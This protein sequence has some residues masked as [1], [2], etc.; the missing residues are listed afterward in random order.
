MKKLIFAV[1]AILVVT[2]TA[3]NSGNT[4]TEATTTDSTCVDSTC[5]DS[6]K[7]DTSAVVD[8]TKK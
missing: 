1:I 6:C 8:T 4:S 5:V 7:V 2:F 3:C